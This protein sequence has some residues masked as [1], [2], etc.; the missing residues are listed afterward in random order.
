MHVFRVA[1][2]LTLTALLLACGREPSAAELTAKGIAN[3]QSAKTAHLD[4][5][6]QIALKGQNGVS[7]SFDL[8]LVGDAQ[9]PDKARMTVQVALGGMTFSI[10]T[11]VIDGKEFTND[12]V[13]GKWS[14]GA[15]SSP[16]NSLMDP[17]GNI[18]E[19]LIRNVVE[20]DR[21][22]VDG[23]KT[24]HLRYQVDSAKMLGQLRKSAGASAQSIANPQGTGELWIRIDDS[25]I[26]R[27][28]VKVTMDVD[29]LA[30][31][32]PAS[33]SNVGKS[34]AELSLDMQF[35]KHGEAVPAI[36]APPVAR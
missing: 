12:G 35:S 24:R 16:I 13:S 2:L 1:S 27:Q 11:I 21:P 9:L 29:G 3:L 4:G 23:R 25:Q 14:D 7:S 18:D 5:S 15:G 10:D 8:K 31:F 28:L 6:A 20:V 19:S 17:L 22:E 30:N 36:T 33:A 26:V 32:L 34:A